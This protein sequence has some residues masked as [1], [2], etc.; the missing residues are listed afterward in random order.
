MS[1]IGLRRNSGR[2]AASD[3]KKTNT[4]TLL[5]NIKSN[6]QLY[7]LALIPVAWFIVFRYLPMYGA[8]IAFKDYKAASGILGSEW[9]GLEN[10]I[11]FFKSYQFGR[12]LANTL[13][14]SLYQLLAGFPLPI[15]LALSIN[16]LRNEKFKKTVQ[17]VTYMPHFISVVV[18]CGMMM[19]FM[20]PRVGIVNEIITA[21]GGDAIDFIAKPEYFKSIYVWSGVWQRFGWGSIIYLATLASVDPNQH[22]AAMIDGASRFKRIIHI[23]IPNIMPTIVTLLILNFGRIMTIGFEKVL[24]LQNDLNLRTSEIISTYTYK[25]GL[26]S[27]FP[28]FSYATAIGLFNSVVNLILIVSINKLAKKINE[29]SLW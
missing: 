26:A 24:L 18:V 29:T 3:W 14:L 22:E 27:A 12:V 2:K 25:I 7:L 5:N 6:Y 21:L 9:V 10:F 16:A 1:T 15:I 28:D 20:S 23:D 4:Q 13:G 19:Q 17:L 8:L 11:K